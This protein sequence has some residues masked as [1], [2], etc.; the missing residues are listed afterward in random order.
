MACFVVGLRSELFSCVPGLAPGTIGYGCTACHHAYQAY[1]QV[2]LLSVHIMQ[3]I[4]A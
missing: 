2:W 3:V 1:Q 4:A